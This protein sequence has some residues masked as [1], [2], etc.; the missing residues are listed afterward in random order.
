MYNYY[1]F[2]KGLVFGVLILFIGLSTIPLTEG[3]RKEKNFYNTEIS[4]LFYLRD[5]DPLN[6][7]D[8]GSLMMGVSIENETTRCGMFVNFHFAQEGIYKGENKI[9][10]I[11]YHFWQKGF[12]HGEYE[13]GYSTS[14]KHTAGFNESIWFDIN[15]YVSETNDFRLIQAM[16]TTNPDIA[17]FTEDEIYNFTIKIFGPNP[18]IICNPKQYSFIILNLENNVTLQNYDRDNDFI[19]DYDELFVYFTNPFDKDT[20]GDGFSDYSEVNYGADPNNYNDNFGE[21]TRPNIPTIKGPL[22]GKAGI[23]YDYIFTSTDPEKNP[24]YYYIIWGDDQNEKWIGH[25]ISGEEVIIS[26]IWDEDGKYTIMA[27][28]RDSKGA[29]SDW[30]TLKVI[31]P[32]NTVLYN[33]SF[34]KIVDQFPLI[35]RL[36][37]LML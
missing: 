4:G 6:W 34:I 26:H 13:L 27:K 30:G 8:V 22:I 14:S 11:Y 33:P 1:I 20:D 12:T 23:K 7:E 19:N 21:N 28:A 17:V 2:Q 5:D 18:Y 15:D 35:K 3:M 37:S 10:N 31:I 29:E 36:F 9:N 24:V 16:Q 25:Y 32:R